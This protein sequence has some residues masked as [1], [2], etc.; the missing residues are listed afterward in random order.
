MTKY[1]FIPFA[2]VIHLSIYIIAVYVCFNY[3]LPPA[4]AIALSCESARM[5]MKTHAYIRDKLMFGRKDNI[6]A[7]EYA[8]F[9]PEY[10]KKLG[11]TVE[12]L[13]LPD[14]T[15]ESTYVELNRMAYF[16]LVPSL[17]YRD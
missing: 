16:F 8:E 14:I 12:D 2:V 15:I 11:V 6:K 1:F 13:N 17:I 7:R 4:S 3:K 10:C 9:M 5:S